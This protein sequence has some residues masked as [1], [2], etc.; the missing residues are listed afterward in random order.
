L[1][2]VPITTILLLQADAIEEGVICYKVVPAL[3]LLM[4][5]ALSKREKLSVVEF[6]KR[7]I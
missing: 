1:P 6:F 3:V 7:E 2:A 5:D 4:E